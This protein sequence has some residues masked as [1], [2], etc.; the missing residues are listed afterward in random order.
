[1]HIDPWGPE[2]QQGNVEQILSFDLFSLYIIL[3]YLELI[4]ICTKYNI[5]NK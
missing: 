5:K 2:I 1:M 3:L 4:A